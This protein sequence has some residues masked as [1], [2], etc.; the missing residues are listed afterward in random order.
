MEKVAVEIMCFAGLRKFFGGGTTVLVESD[1]TYSDIID[2]MIRMKP[3][4]EKV[5]S[6]CRIA[7]GDEFIPPEEKIKSERK[8]ILIPPSSGG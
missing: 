6:A 1:A 8:I 5:V 7:V 4:A 2:E 3:D